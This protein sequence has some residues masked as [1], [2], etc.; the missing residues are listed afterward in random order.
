MSR[1]IL[2]TIL[3]LSFVF[4][5]AAQTDYRSRIAVI[6][7]SN[8][9]GRDQYNPLCSTITETVSLVLQFLKDYKL[10][11]AEDADIGRLEEAGMDDLE[12]LKIL[13]EEEGV[14]EI[15]FGRM[16]ESGGAFSFSIA[17]F[18]VNEGRIT[19]TQSVRA[20]TVLDV[21]DAG[22]ELTEGLI[23]QLSDVTIAFGS[24]SLLQT[25]GKGNY[26]VKLD[27]Y[28]LRNPEKIF[29]KVLNGSY[30]V[31]I[32]QH[33]LTGEQTVYL[34]RV[35]VREGEESPVE[36]EIPPGSPEE[37]EWMEE[38]GSAL[39]ALG[40]KEESFDSFMEE[41]TLFQYS[42]RALE[43]DADLEGLRDSYMERAA[44]LASG[45]LQAR[46]D[47]VDGSFYDR[48]VDFGETLTR[49]QQM[50]SLVNTHYDIQILDS[51]GDTVFS[52]P[53]KIQSDGGSRVAFSAFDRNKEHSLF[54]WDRTTDT[55]HSRSLKGEPSASYDGEFVLTSRRVFLREPGSAELE[56]MDHRLQTKEILPVPDLDGEEEGI[57]MALSP[58]N[59]VYLISSGIIRVIDTA[60]EYDESGE[61]LLP[62]RYYSIEENLESSLSD[63][64]SAPGE[65]FFDSARH[66]NVFYPS[67]GMLYIFDMRGNLLR[68][69]YLAESQPESC[70]AVDN[71]GFIYLTLY[72][73]NTLLKYTPSGDLISSFGRYGSNPG[74]FSLPAGI[75]LNRDGVL[76]VSDSYNGRI[77]SMTPLTIPV[78]Y[79]EV[80]R[81]GEDL[82]R[83]ID[84]SRIAVL[85]DK[86]A[87]EDIGWKNH[88]GNMLG[89]AVALG[90]TFGFVLAGD[91]FGNNWANTIYDSTIEGKPDPEGDARGDKSAQKGMD[92]L[93][94][95]S[96]G[97]AAGYATNTLLGLGLD[98]T[99]SRYNRR[100]IQSLDM[101]KEYEVDPDRYRSIRRTSQIGIWTGIV[102][103]VLGA[104]T[105]TAIAA[106]EF[107]DIDIS[108]GYALMGS[109]ILPPMFSHLHAGRF[110]PG[111]LGAGIVADLLAVWGFMELTDS[112]NDDNNM[113]GWYWSVD[114]YAVGHPDT[115]NMG[116]AFERSSEFS[117]VYLL[118]AAFGIRIA[119]GIYDA[120]NG[121]IYTNNYNRYKA[122]RERQ[123]QAETSSVDVNILPYVHPAGGLGM[124]MNF[125]F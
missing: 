23:A 123:V 96:F 30:E 41:L 11:D 8:G 68:T 36:F 10:V 82:D 25:G 110:S 76:L 14:N 48:S 100:Q 98:S 42:T 16:E 40:G 18:N 91:F 56:I 81:Y 75:A 119:A 4:P 46:M 27:G 79:P 1:K 12:S 63:E 9:T 120:R 125:A 44:E 59:Q 99:L 69:L 108:L 38:K 34:E 17:L 24:I 5:L 22:D 62:D 106:N 31:S 47:E 80:A 72:E 58:E 52:E 90:T 114:D 113:G 70:I 3:M 13:A 65:A 26:T 51:S 19:N 35:E 50:S 104:L 95:V 74:E 103:P 105:F 57:K 112:G 118:A 122:V 124:A 116:R 111:L 88:A 78:V 86:G 92:M 53:R 71:S 87:R 54:L 39:L 6:P 61:L 20:E 121:W 28:P 67:S 37:F 115:V 83:R 109:I 97:A 85:K 101:D 89:T 64:D 84:R 93:S 107:N 29:R 21:F 77:Q 49:Y 7:L 55:I 94:F 2:L 33:R 102:P 45:T 66:L 43:Y 60:R 32:T 73:Q 15:V 117:G